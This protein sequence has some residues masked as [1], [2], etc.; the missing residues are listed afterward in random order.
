MEGGGLWSK[1]KKYLS[2]SKT[3]TIPTELD[4]YR[5]RPSMMGT[6]PLS[7][8]VG[9]LNPTTPFTTTGKQ[10]YLDQKE[11]ECKLTQ[12]HLMEAYKIEEAKVAN[13]KAKLSVFKSSIDES[14]AQ[15][16]A[17]VLK[18]KSRYGITAREYN[19]RLEK[20]RMADEFYATDPYYKEIIDSNS[21]RRKA[22][23]TEAEADELAKFDKKQLEDAIKRRLTRLETVELPLP[24]APTSLPVL[25]ARN[26]RSDLLPPVP[27]DPFEGGRKGRKR[28]RHVRF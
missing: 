2:P 5:H 3:A 12:D 10:V 28:G 1:L 20:L 26:F 21:L 24:A 6:G 4:L 13:I 8:I 23:I 19:E 15:C 9:N 25:E 17:R 14:G 22:N 16:D 11:L 27:N 18:S 7:E